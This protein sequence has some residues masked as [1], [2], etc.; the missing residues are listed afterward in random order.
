MR[1]GNV[2]IG[3]VKGYRSKADSVEPKGWKKQDAI[4]YGKKLVDLGIKHITVRNKIEENY[5]GS[6][7]EMKEIINAVLD[8]KELKKK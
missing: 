1:T 6:K 2:M 7:S 5:P 3:A 8:Y 4:N